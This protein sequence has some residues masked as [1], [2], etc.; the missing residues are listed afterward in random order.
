MIAESTQLEAPGDRRERV[1]LAV[2]GGDDGG[3]GLRGSWMVRRSSRSRPT[4]RS[5]RGGASGGGADELADAEGEVR[6]GAGEDG[7]AMRTKSSAAMTRRGEAL[8][9]AVEGTREVAEDA[10]ERDALLRDAPREDVAE[11]RERLVG[12]RKL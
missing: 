2:G 10:A 5:V 6:G 4:T 1:R 11:A 3:R 8:E 9:E 12:W 7:A